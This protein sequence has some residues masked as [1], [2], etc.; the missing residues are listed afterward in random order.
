M[1]VGIDQ[2][3][4]G[5]MVP[6]PP[7]P[8]SE[9]E[10]M[11]NWK[12]DISTPIVSMEC[13]TFNHIK[14]IR[15]A[16]NGLLMQ[17]TDFPFEIILHDDA[18]TD[19][20]TEIVK[21]YAEVYPNIIVAI[22]QTENQ[23]SKGR[24]P[25]EFT[26]KTAKGN[27]ISSCEGDDYWLDKEK[28][29]KQLESLRSEKNIVMSYHDALVIDKDGKLT[30]RN[31]PSKNGYSKAELKKAPFVPTLTRLFKNHDI[32]WIDES[33]LPASMDVVVTS[34]LSRYGGAVFSSN[35][36]PCVYR[37]HDGGVWSVKSNT[38]KASMTIDTMLFIASQYE[39]ES[40]IKG[41]RFF[42]KRAFISGLASQP[43]YDA[44]Y[45]TSNLSLH[46]LS[47]VTRNIYNGIKGVRNR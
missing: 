8:R 43:L 7:K 26:F 18:S 37:H 11:A 47:K 41:K 22:I 17:E 46:I 1:D 2:L 13:C 44:L 16:L 10:I 4:I 14:F 38:E 45:V 12:G 5:D 25:W 34:Y 28:I 20:T 35:V 39:K 19:G 15:H 21:E 29:S 30:G 3:K 23:W 42:L 9:Q 36:V 33:S 6:V 27:Y 32:T 31:K 24:R 40:D